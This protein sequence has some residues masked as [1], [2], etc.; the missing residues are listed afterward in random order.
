MAT[1]CY[2]YL[3]GSNPSENGRV[4]ELEQEILETY[5][6]VQAKIEKQAQSFSVDNGNSDD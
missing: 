1:R 3:F 6:K 4:G 5:F 2:N